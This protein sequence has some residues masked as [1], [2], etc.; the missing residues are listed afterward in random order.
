MW[1]VAIAIAAALGVRYWLLF[2]PHSYWADKGVEQGPP[3]F[4]VWL[5]WRT[6]IRKLAIAEMV[7][8]VYNTCPKTR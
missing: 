1:W 8:V 5:N 3:R 2:R 6:I 7:E 4:S